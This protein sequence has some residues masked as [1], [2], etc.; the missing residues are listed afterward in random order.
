MDPAH[1]DRPDAR[2]AASP[3]PLQPLAAS[4]LAC[5]PQTPSTTTTTGEAAWAAADLVPLLR[6]CLLAAD[7]AAPALRGFCEAAEE[8]E[9][10]RSAARDGAALC[11]PRYSARCAG[12]WSPAWSA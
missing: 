9:E 2:P 12:A 8:G 11:R 1:C 7:C 4:Y 6:M 3:W 10:A 5:Q